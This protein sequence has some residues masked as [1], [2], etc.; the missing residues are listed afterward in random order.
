MLPT[1]ETGITNKEKIQEM[2]V[3]ISCNMNRPIWQPFLYTEEQAVYFSVQC[4]NLCFGRKMPMYT[5][6]LKHNVFLNQQNYI[7]FH[8]TVCRHQHI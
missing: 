1:K 2:A 6:I 8:S 4:L 5:C 3:F 7:Y